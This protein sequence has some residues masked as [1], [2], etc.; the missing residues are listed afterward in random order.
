MDPSNL[1]DGDILFQ[2]SRSLQSRAIQMATHSEISH[3]GILF[4]TQDQWQVYEAVLPVKWTPLKAWIRKGI[5]GQVVVKRLK[6][7]A[8]RL[9]PQVLARMREVGQRFQ[10]K[11][12][13]LTF[14][15]SDD[16][17]YCS[18]LVWKIYKEGAGIELGTLQKLE[19][20]DLSAPVVRAKLLARFQ[21][22]LP[23]E[24]PVITPQQIFD[25]P[26]LETI[27]QR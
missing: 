22:H 18:E 26:E 12:Y 24:E 19:D 7:R 6:D 13:D 2:A 20:L 9:T 4:R 16:R 5:H 3:L 10:G 11:P 14:D 8:H 1:Q 21:G 17:I 25:C 27:A 23:L 15:W